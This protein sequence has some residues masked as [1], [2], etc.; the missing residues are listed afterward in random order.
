MRR[1]VRSIRRDGFVLL[2]VLLALLALFALSAPFLATARNADAASHQGADAAQLRLALDGAERHARYSLERTHPA[3]DETPDFD[4]ATELEVEVDFPEGFVDPHD[5]RGVAWDVE[6]TDLSGRVDLASAPPQVIAALTGSVTRLS[7]PLEAAADELPLLQPERFGEGAVVV[8]NGESIQLGGATEDGGRAAE[9]RGIGTDVDDEGNVLSNGPAPRRGHGLGSYVLD[10]RAFA[11]AVWRTLSIDGSPRRLD[12]VEEVRAAEE[13]SLSGGYG[14]AEMAALRR[15]S[16]LTAPAGRDA[17]W[18]RPVRVFNPLIAGETYL[19]A[20]RQ[21][22]WFGVG[23]TVK[24]ESRSG[25][26]LRVVIARENDGRIRLDRAVDL[27]HEAP[28]TWISAL[29]RR[30]VNVNSAPEPVLLALV[31]NLKLRGQNHRITAR[32]ATALAAEI[33]RLRP[34]TGFQDFVERLVLPAGGIDSDEEVEPGTGDVAAPVLDDPRD[35]VALYTNALNANDARLEFSTM[36]V[37]FTSSGSFE[38]ELRAAVN[39]DTGLERTSGERG[40]IVRV[41]PEGGEILRVFTRQ[42]DFDR[43]LRLGRRAPYW[44]TGPASTGRYDGGVTPPSRVV[45][46]IGTVRGQRFLPGI[47]EPILDADGNPLPTE[48]VF[49]DSV[50]GAGRATSAGSGG[51]SDFGFVS[52]DPIRVLPTG[53]T[54]GRILHFDQESRSLDGRY[55]PDA[56]VVRD[57]SDGVARWASGTGLALPVGLSMWVR[58]ESPGD[59]TLL[60]VGGASARNDRVVLG[61]SGEDLVLEV[62]DGMGDHPMTPFQEIT[63][64]RFP[65]AGDANAP[66]LPA[67]IWSHVDLDVRG[68]RPDQVDLIVN[69]SR[70]GVQREGMTRL[71]A[72]LSAGATGIPVESTEGFPDVC[73]LRIGS[74]LIEAVRTGDNGFQAIHAD[75]GENAGFGGRLARVRFDTEGSPTASPT[76]LASALTTGAYPA[77]TTVSLYGYSMPLAEG[78]PAGGAVL[79]APIGE[80]R[81]ARVAPMPS[82]NSL[83]PINFTLGENLIPLGRGWLGTQTGVLPLAPADLNGTLEDTLAAFNPGG[84][85]AVLSGP[86]DL[87][88]QGS[89]LGELTGTFVGGPEIVRYSGVTPTGLQVVERGIALAGG[90]TPP[91]Q[92]L[93]QGKSFVFDWQINFEQASAPS[94]PGNDILG[95]ATFCYPISIPAPGIGEF[96][97]AVPLNGNSAFAQVTRLD[98]PELTEW[99]RY[100]TIDVPASQL[101]RSD[102]GV[103]TAVSVALHSG[104]SGQETFA[105]AFQPGGGG[106]APGIPGGGGGLPGLPGGKTSSL[107]RT[108][109]LPRAGLASAAAPLPDWDARRGV[110]L[111]EDLPLTRTVASILHFRGVLGTQ[112]QAHPAGVQVLPVFGIRT[113]DFTVDVGRPGRFD[114]VFIT[115]GDATSVGFPAMVHRAHY[116]A[117]ERVQ[118]SWSSVPDGTLLATPGQPVVVPQLGIPF[119]GYVALETSLPAPTG[120]GTGVQQPP[121]GQGIAVLDERLLARMTKFPSGELPR[122]VTGAVLGASAGGA[123]DYGVPDA[124]IDEVVFGGAIAFRGVGGPAGAITATEGAPM[125]VGESFDPSSLSF[126]VQQASLRTPSG[127]VSSLTPVVSALSASGGLLRI[128]EEILCYSGYDPLEGEITVAQGGRGMLGTRPQPHIISEPVH[129]MEDWRATTLAAPVGPDDATLTL[130][131]LVDFPREGTVLIGGELIHYTQIFGGALAMPR[132][133]AEPG[134]MDD[135]GFGAFRGRYGTTPQSHAAG[136][137]VILFPARYH[138]RYAP[139]FDAPELAYFGLEVEDPGS[140]FTGVTWRAIESSI[141]G[142]EVI[143]LQR[144]G[145]APWDG[146]PEEDP[147]LMLMQDGALEGG[148]WPIDLGGDRI[149]W[150][151]F[152]RYPPGAFDPISGLAHGWKETPRF[153]E[154]AVTYR[155][156]SAV[157]RSV[158]R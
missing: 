72:N 24:I 13:F 11:V 77:G 49:A 76:T 54:Q 143:V 132:T 94:A 95:A 80:F 122:A 62:F 148:R 90:L 45:P 85:Y 126:R 1:P 20:V 135:E 12:V 111:L 134:A 140:F 144:L 34:F 157:L 117:N 22:R 26:E 28:G 65:L 84:G 139:R 7:A 70:V 87:R 154:L 114:P 25:P 74:E 40:R 115:E 79:T 82:D 149:Q 158:K 124:T 128:G 50:S 59:G 105:P 113:N 142:P 36:P 147:R 97:F 57:P 75:S 108:R 69:G 93:A 106:G 129:W 116:P 112:G 9:T 14:D 18:Q 92:D 156:Q 55:L 41:A 136:A 125:L 155:A 39:G 146:D 51:V 27:S 3:L 46:H 83:S 78:V 58:P 37:A 133:S 15:L 153:E 60:S 67:G 137:P 48:R 38:F 43:A 63:R 102:P 47:D 42:E 91:G 35:A 100:D 123:F 121:S 17:A 130:T 119:R 96:D 64:V 150:R 56:A 104:I 21:G 6:A 120:L 61:M 73:V 52:L 103:I 99:V 141:G 131:S 107:M 118:H 33:V 101:V 81:V 71:S 44:L 4:D 145:D 66:G 86:G 109:G 8:I 138:D 151:V 152:A 98:D 88:F 53:R 10:E 5:P 127:N 30:P 89:T 16:H 23:T 2:A 110:D 31:E 68:T 19:V 29:V 32:E